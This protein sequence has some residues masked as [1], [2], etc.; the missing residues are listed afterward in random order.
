MKIPKKRVLKSSL[1]VYKEKPLKMSI[2]PIIIS[3]PAIIATPRGLSELE[4][5]AFF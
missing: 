2:E 5:E 3:R 1:N 4:K